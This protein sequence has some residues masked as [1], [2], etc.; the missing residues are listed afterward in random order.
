MARGRILGQRLKR[1]PAISK[2]TG[3]I[4]DSSFS[5]RLA[6]LA[7]ILVVR[8]TQG[9]IIIDVIWRY[10]RIRLCG[11]RSPFGMEDIHVKTRVAGAGATRGLYFV[12]C[13]FP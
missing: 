2:R 4:P 11:S 8:I 10:S 13:F 1:E 12:A 6:L 7:S 5:N 3:I 9:Q